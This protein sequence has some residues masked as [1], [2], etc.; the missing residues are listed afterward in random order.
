MSS[1][2]INER[3]LEGLVL[4]ARNAIDTVIELKRSSTE[5]TTRYKEQA[6]EE[7]S[8][9][10]SREVYCNGTEAAL[11]AK[12]RD[13][14]RRKGYLFLRITPASGQNGFP[15]CIVYAKS[16]AHYLIEFKTATGYLSGSQK[17]KH[18]EL[19]KLGFAVHVV[20]DFATFKS[21]VNGG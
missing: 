19:E 7:G 3:G 21:L 6:K 12:C 16:G 11:Q 17:A 10:K 2:C 18:K 13:Y 5:C 8:P 9:M 20:R 4:L 14:C 15:D 1:V